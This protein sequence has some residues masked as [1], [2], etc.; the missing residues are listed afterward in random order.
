MTMRLLAPVLV[1][2]SVAACA[3]TETAPSSRSSP[4]VAT[5][6]NSAA[7]AHTHRS[8]VNPGA[9]GSPEDFKRSGPGCAC[10]SNPI[11]GDCKCLHCG[12]QPGAQCYCQE[13]KPSCV[14]GIDM[15][16]CSC[17][18]C[19]GREGKECEICPCDHTATRAKLGLK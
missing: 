14:C 6:T 10:P 19:A 2:L 13:S 12:G 17:V 7:P 4:D 18:H 3:T 8:G 5:R 1:A 16:L 11:L 15:P 9:P